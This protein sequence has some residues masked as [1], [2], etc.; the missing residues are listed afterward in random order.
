MDPNDVHENN[1]FNIYTY[2]LKNER[3]IRDRQVEISKNENENNITS[4]ENTFLTKMGEI[5][6]KRSN[7][8]PKTLRDLI[9]LLKTKLKTKLDTLIREDKKWVEIKENVKQFNDLM[10]SVPEIKKMSN[11]PRKLYYKHKPIKINKELKTKNKNLKY[12][13]DTL[14][15]TRE[16]LNTLKLVLIFYENLPNISISDCLRYLKDNIGIIC[17][18][19]GLKTLEENLIKSLKKEEYNNTKFNEG[20]LISPFNK[21]VPSVNVLDHDNY[22]DILNMINKSFYN[23][24][25]FEKPV[26]NQHGGSVLDDI[27]NTNYIDE[28]KNNITNLFDNIKEIENNII[29]TEKIYY[30]KNMSINA[31]IFTQIVINKLHNDVNGEFFV[32]YMSYYELK[33]LHDNILTG[34]NDLLMGIKMKTKKFLKRMIDIISTNYIDI[35]IKTIWIELKYNN[36]LIPLLIAQLLMYI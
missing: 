34:E 9:N 22:D 16:E 36:S 3:L 12:N 31:M 18:D 25:K 11:I 14:K 10:L 24:M 32:K 23:I 1:F 33:E 19:N 5:I 26:V 29:E 4:Y 28:Y 17:E 20:L 6:S 7:N 35:D 2:D 8:I 21:N 15:K 13:T 30:Y 27:K